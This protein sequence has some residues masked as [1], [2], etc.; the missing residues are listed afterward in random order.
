MGRGKRVSRWDDLGVDDYRDTLLWRCCGLLCRVH[1]SDNDGVCWRELST[2][3]GKDSARL[4]VFRVRDFSA[5][6]VNGGRRIDAVEDFSREWDAFSNEG[7]I[8]LGEER[9]IFLENDL[10]L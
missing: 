8:H 10:A 3:M 6:E 2:I 5:V 1:C 4:L 7:R 9:R